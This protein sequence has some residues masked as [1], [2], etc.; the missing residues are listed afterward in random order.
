MEV[1]LIM[2][3][4]RGA[5]K[6]CIYRS[7]RPHWMASFNQVDICVNQWVLVMLEVTM[8]KLRYLLPD[9]AKTAND[10]TSWCSWD[11]SNNGIGPLTVIP[12]L[13]WSFWIPSANDTLSKLWH[14]DTFNGYLQWI[15]S[16]YG[17]LLLDD[18]IWC[19][20]MK[21]FDWRPSTED[22]Q[23]KTLNWRPSLLIEYP[24][25]PKRYDLGRDI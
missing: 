19:P 23:L 7:W 25:L 1:H 22:L 10:D 13:L 16:S 15:P 18:P 2:A 5:F 17:K 12:S 9:N 3:C 8:M 4:P 24:Q 21:T 14:V 20:Q 6:K 11:M